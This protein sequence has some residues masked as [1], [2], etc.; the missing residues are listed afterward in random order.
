VRTAQVAMCPASMRV[1]PQKVPAP[2]LNVPVS[3]FTLSTVTNDPPVGSDVVL[4]PFGRPESPFA[5]N[6]KHTAI[7][8][9]SESWAMTDCDK[10]LLTV[11]G[12]T[13][14]TYID[15]IAREPVHGS[16]MPALRQYLYYDWSVRSARTP[17]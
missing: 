6:Q 14:A 8:K 1:L 15:Y 9:P 16:K 10:Q 13:A 4:F 12:I 2:P 17:R 7:R 5:P 11:M 3:Y